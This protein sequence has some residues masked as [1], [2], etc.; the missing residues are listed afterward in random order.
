MRQARRFTHAEDAFIG[1]NSGRITSTAIARHL[2]RN[3]ASVVSRQVTLGLREPN[4]R[5]RKFSAEEDRVI[6]EGAGRVS[7]YDIAARLG[8]KP[9][10]VYGRAKTLGLD[11]DAALR[12]ARRRIKDGY[13]WVPIMD[14]GRRH[15]RAE[16]RHVV[17]TRLGRPL[18]SSEAVHHIDLDPLNN[19]DGNLYVCRSNAEHSAIHHQLVRVI[20]QPAVVCRLL[21]LGIIAF[22]NAGGCYRLCETHN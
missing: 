15:W 6:R 12:P 9:S 22:D 8:R 11:F 10:S 7:M 5:V 2:G 19:A 13:A 20:A 14:G 21:E 16:H 1:E 3:P 17:A 18:R 4:R